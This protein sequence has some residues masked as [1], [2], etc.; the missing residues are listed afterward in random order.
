MEQGFGQ[1]DQM[2]NIIS[3]CVCDV[4]VLIHTLS[5]DAHYNGWFIRKL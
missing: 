1:Q 4:C 3:S 5:M 2:S